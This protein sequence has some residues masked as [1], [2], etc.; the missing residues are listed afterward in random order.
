MESPDSNFHKTIDRRQ[1]EESRAKAVWTYCFLLAS[2][3]VLFA[4]Y[5]LYRGYHEAVKYSIVVMLVFSAIYVLFRKTDTKNKATAVLI[6]N[7]Y[8]SV[9]CIGLFVNA[10]VYPAIQ[11]SL[12]AIPIGMC[13]AYMLLGIRAATGWLVVSIIAYTSYALVSYGLSASLPPSEIFDDTLLKAGACI[14]VFLC[15]REFES[16]F[17]QRA[18]ELVDLS[19]RLKDKSQELNVLATTDTLTGLPNR[20]QFNHAIN[21]LVKDVINHNDTLALLVLDMNG[22]KQVNDTLGHRV[23]DEALVEIAARLQQS[24]NTQTLVARLGGDEFCVLFQGARSR[25]DIESFSRKLHSRLCEEYYLTN[26]S[27]SLGVSIGIACCPEDAST[28]EDLFTFADTA[29]FHAKENHYPYAFYEAKQTERI[30]EYCSL[31]ERLSNALQQ[32]EFYL[33]YQPQFDILT[34]KIIGAEALLRWRHDGKIISPGEFIPH[35]EGSRQIVIVTKWVLDAVCAQIQQWNDIGMNIKIAVNISAIDFHDPQFIETITSAINKYQIQA[36]QLELEVTE[37]VFIENVEDVANK[38]NRLKQNH[39]TIS[40]DD[41][42]TGYSSLAY[43]RRLPVDKLK[44]DREF[45]KNY[46]EGDEGTIA[47]TVIFLAKKLG[48]TVLAEGVETESQLQFLQS[49]SCDQ[50]QGF[51]ASKPIS[52]SELQEIVARINGDNQSDHKMAG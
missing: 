5:F 51:L 30:V 15:L 24:S 21:G 29:M 2:G 40:I 41:F 18:K 34:G 19:Q 43:I 47:S 9:H 26:V 42:G 39:I 1:I 31:Q 13:I 35:L 50:F 48:L 44:I 23:G 4:F 28:A 10:V 52:A 38:L 6:T 27:C 7:T 32:E 33:D 16:F 22:F 36:D 17:N 8:L 45:I 37:G 46:P 14:V 20:H 11:S 12:L 3:W 49:N 25:R